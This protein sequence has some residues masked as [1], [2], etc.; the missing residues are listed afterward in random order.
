MNKY[1]WAFILP[2]LIFSLNCG[3]AKKQEPKNEAA[4]EKKETPVIEEKTEKAETMDDLVYE[5]TGISILKTESAARS[6]AELKGRVEIIKALGRDAA[7]LGTVFAALQKELFAEGLDTAAFAKAIREYFGK[8][9]IML[10][11]SSVSEY[12]RSEKGDSTF[13]LMEMPLMAGYDVIES[14]ILTVGLKSKFLKA[15]AVDNFK[16]N[17]HEFFMAEKKKLLTKPS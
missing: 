15:D 8:E 13:A 12:S 6:Q 1:G 10:K 16:K 9:K 3:E 2:M 17:F 14:A 7:D 4:S 11:G 5:E